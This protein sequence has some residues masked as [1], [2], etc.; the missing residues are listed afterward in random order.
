MVA[1]PVTADADNVSKS[2][3]TAAVE[4]NGGRLN[5]WM[6]LLTAGTAEVQREELQ[7]RWK[8]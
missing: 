3:K 4:T 5:A 8:K 7:V 2:E 1:V 6:D